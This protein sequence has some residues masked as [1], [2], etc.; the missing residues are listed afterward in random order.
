MI[1]KNEETW[2]KLTEKTNNPSKK[3]MEPYQKNDNQSNPG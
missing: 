3:F 1:I 2:E